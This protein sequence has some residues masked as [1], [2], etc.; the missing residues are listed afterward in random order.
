MKWLGT[1]TNN[2]RLEVTAERPVY[3]AGMSVMFSGQFTEVDPELELKCI[4]GVKLDN[5]ELVN[6]NLQMDG[7]YRG[8][9]L[10][11]PS[12]EYY[13]RPFATCGD[14]VIQGQKGRVVVDTYSVEWAEVGTNISYWKTLP[15]R[16]GSTFRLS[17]RRCLSWILIIMWIQK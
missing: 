5:G 15:R 14:N 7:F 17:A 10:K 4:V 12:G 16:T 6:L 8:R 13:Y 9:W 2:N 1:H 11:P 3:R